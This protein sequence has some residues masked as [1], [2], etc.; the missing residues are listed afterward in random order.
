MFTSSQARTEVS[1]V[2]I[3]KSPLVPL[4]TFFCMLSIVFL[5][6]SLSL[7]LCQPLSLSLPLSP[8]LSVLLYFPQP[9]ARTHWGLLLPKEGRINLYKHT[10]ISTQT[11]ML[12]EVYHT[13]LQTTTKT[14]CVL[15]KLRLAR[16]APFAG[17]VKK[18][19]TPWAQV[20]VGKFANR[21]FAGLHFAIQSTGLLSG[22][23][24]SSWPARLS[25]WPAFCV[26]VRE[27]IR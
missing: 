9:Q 10:H 1:C 14:A 16:V 8:P 21:V 7:I 17:C 13:L 2:L 18:A 12:G 24:T 27:E 6:P 19:E 20:V 26:R 23:F 3:K 25:M 4:L 11:H 22:L 15:D 5:S